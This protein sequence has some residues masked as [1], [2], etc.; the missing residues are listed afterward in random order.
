[1]TAGQRYG[2][3][4][5]RQSSSVD[6]CRSYWPVAPGPPA[7]EAAHAGPGRRPRTPVAFPGSQD[8]NRW[9]G[10]RA[11]SEPRSVAGVVG[12]SVNVTVRWQADILDRLLD[13]PHAAMVERVVT[14]LHGLGWETWVEA[15]FSLNGE[16]GS[17]DV[18]AWQ[19]VFRAL[20]VIEVKAWTGDSQDT[21]AGV[22]RK[23]RV[24]ARVAGQRR[25]TPRTVSALLAIGDTRTM[26]R[27]IQRLDSTY[28]AAF[29]VRGRDVMR[30]LRNPA[31]RTI[32]GLLF[33]S[34]VTP[35]DAPRLRVVRRRGPG[36]QPRTSAGRGES[37]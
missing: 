30:W 31:T 6:G 15:T 17:I 32:R 37:E 22:D 1:M 5:R 3:N 13:H 14:L 19:P 12:A 2:P 9:R 25:W 21:L 34:S 26:R 35:G 29:P 10:W 20:L 27:R 4:E 11:A 8:R 7:Q 33:L 28:R 36:D 16:R 18:L 23:T 24:A